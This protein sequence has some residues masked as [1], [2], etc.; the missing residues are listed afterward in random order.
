MP[1]PVL[2]CDMLY[3]MM[4]D[5]MMEDDILCAMMDDD[6]ME[7]DMLYGMMDDDM[8]DDDVED[9]G[10]ESG[11]AGRSG[12]VACD[13]LL[14]LDISPLSLSIGDVNGVAVRVVPRNTTIPV[15][16][17]VV[18]VTGVDFQVILDSK[19]YSFVTGYIGHL[20]VHSSAKLL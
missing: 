5:D 6:M 20:K 15:R 11:R 8:M 17:K 7:D 3:D 4:E 13:D 14:L 18:G 10:E 19:L 2:M 9:S 12:R 16:R 1:P